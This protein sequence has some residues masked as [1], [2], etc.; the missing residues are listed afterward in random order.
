MILPIGISFFIF[1]ALSYILWMYIEE[2]YMR[3]NYYK[4]VLYVSFFPQ[5]AA[6]SIER[7]VNI[8]K[9]ISEPKSFECFCEEKNI[10]HG[11]LINIS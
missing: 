11:G 6:G 9:Q 1:Q 8:I 5:L 7:F 3:K 10:L 4:Y 2:K